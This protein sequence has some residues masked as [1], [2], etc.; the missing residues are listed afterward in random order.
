MLMFGGRLLKAL[1]GPLVGEGGTCEES[2]D[3]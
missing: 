3:E 2:E 1:R